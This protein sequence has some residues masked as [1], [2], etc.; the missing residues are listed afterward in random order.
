MEDE[1]FLIDFVIRRNSLPEDKH[2]LFWV[3][4]F[5]AKGLFVQQQHSMQTLEKMFNTESQQP[6]CLILSLSP[7]LFLLLI[8][9]LSL[10]PSL[11]L[12]LPSLLIFILVKHL[13]FS[14]CTYVY[15]SIYNFLSLRIFFSLRPCHSQII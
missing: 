5:E 7:S 10:P 15:L 3:F 9:S 11:S 14:I 1:R 12:S 4:G 13:P 2:G 6:I 8:L